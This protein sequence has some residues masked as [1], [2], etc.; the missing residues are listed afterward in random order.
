M[1]RI[2]KTE[3]EF[4]KDIDR[5]LAGEK[6]S[7]DEQMSDEY[8]FNMEIAGRMLDC[9]SEPSDAYK[10]EL[11]SRLLVKLHEK[12]RASVIARKPSFWDN[13]L[14]NLFPR[15]NAWKLVPAHIAIAVISLLAIWGSN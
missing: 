9:R 6:I 11:K 13:W 8:R 12:E 7:D 15:Q 10:K 1:G 3:K 4:T 5:L 14:S 2:D